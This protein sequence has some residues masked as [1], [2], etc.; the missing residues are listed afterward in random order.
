MPLQNLQK[1]G[2]IT[3]KLKEIQTAIDTINL[4]VYTAR[5]LFEH[6]NTS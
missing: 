3:V 6:V 4:I 5:V 2:K 1:H